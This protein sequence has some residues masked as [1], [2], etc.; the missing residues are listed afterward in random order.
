MFGIFAG[1]ANG[2]LLEAANGLVVHIIQLLF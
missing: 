1:A 2:L